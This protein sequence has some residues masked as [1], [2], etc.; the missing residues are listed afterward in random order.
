VVFRSVEDST[1][2]LNIVKRVIG[3]PT[4]TLQMTH[5]TIYAT[6]NGSTSRTPCTW[7]LTPTIRCSC[8]RSGRYSCPITSGATGPLPPT[9]HDWGPIAIPVGHY[10]VMGDN[11]D[12]S[13][14][15]R[16]WGFLPRSHIVGKPLIIYLS[17]ATDPL[18]SAGT[19]CCAAR[20]SLD[21]PRR[22]GY[23]PSP[24]LKA[25]D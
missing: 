9:T 22:S 5:D 6:A 11:R 25:M 23:N 3:G 8:G 20:G 13:Y 21:A 12:E 17:V 4:D 19:G 15:S 14:D 10:W 1:P 2:N 24:V 18:R 16:F 7:G